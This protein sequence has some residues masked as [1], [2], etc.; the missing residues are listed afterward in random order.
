MVFE[1]GMIQITGVEGIHPKYI[2]KNGFLHRVSDISKHFSILIVK[3][4]RVD[5]F[6]LFHML[7]KLYGIKNILIL[8]CLKRS[9]KER[10]Y[11]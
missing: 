4:N 1:K 8:Y 3:N 10:E 11:I 6:S 2:C 9:V 7:C 5:V